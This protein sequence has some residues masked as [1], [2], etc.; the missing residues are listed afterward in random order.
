VI[1]QTVTT[2]MMVTMRE[3]RE[4]MAR[5]RLGRQKKN[6]NKIIGILLKVRFLPSNKNAGHGDGK[7]HIPSKERET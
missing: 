1:G 2:T 4:V 3:R 7:N 6:E 5:P